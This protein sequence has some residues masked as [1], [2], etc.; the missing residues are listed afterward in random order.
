[1]SVKRRELQEDAEKE[2]ANMD[3][4]PPPLVGANPLYV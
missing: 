1:M 3:S 2:E 4:F